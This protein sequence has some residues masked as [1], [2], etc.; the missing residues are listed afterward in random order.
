[1]IFF[2]SLHSSIPAPER[3]QAYVA[4]KPVA[5]ATATALVAV[6]A[7]VTIPPYGLRQGFI[8][9]TIDHFGDGGAFPE[10]H[11]MQYP[12]DMGRKDKVPHRQF[13]SPRMLE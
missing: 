7:K 6:G 8:P 13:C 2:F 4:P 10:V 12:L 9:R 3:S 1:L 5:T 11:I